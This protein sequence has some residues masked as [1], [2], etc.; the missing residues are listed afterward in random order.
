MFRHKK[1]V[2]YKKFVMGPGVG[3]VEEAREVVG[4]GRLWVVGG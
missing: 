3:K 2:I 1:V 4:G